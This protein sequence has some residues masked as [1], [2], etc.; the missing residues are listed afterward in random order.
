MLLLL[1]EIVH[2]CDAVLARRK[3]ANHEQ[4]LILLSHWV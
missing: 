4:Q 1:P 2:A 3:S